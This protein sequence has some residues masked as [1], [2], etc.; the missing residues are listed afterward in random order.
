M[1]AR[2]GIVENSLVSEANGFV[3]SLAMTVF[4]KSEHLH[5]GEGERPGCTSWC[6]ARQEWECSSKRTVVRRDAE[7]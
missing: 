2:R 7:G 4:V 3:G 5:S 6:G 1:T